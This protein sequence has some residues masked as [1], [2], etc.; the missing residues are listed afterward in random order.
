MRTFLGILVSIL[1]ATELRA[2]TGTNHYFPNATD[3][4][5]VDGKMFNRVLS[6]NWTTLPAQGTTLEVLEVATNGV[7]LQA[8]KSDG[9]GEKILVKHFPGS[10]AKG[11]AM[12]TPLRAM[13]VASV[14]YGAETLTAY[15]CGLPNTR[16]NRKTLVN[17]PIH[18]TN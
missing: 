16:E 5:I 4:R 9:T 15:D 6:T 8:R 14:K 13:P 1:A 7:V 17:G 3:M 12:T 18:S 2:Q 11:K 10:P